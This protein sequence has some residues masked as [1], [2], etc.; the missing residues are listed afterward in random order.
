MG[1]STSFAGPKG[2]GW[3]TAKTS[4]TRLAKGR[5]GYTPRRVVHDAASAITS[6]G[7]A[8]G[9]GGGW[10]GSGASRTA[11]RLGGLLGGAVETGLGDS[12]ERFGI[13]NLHDVP[14]S[15]ALMRLLD[16]VAADAVD[17]NDQAAR[18]AAEDV[19]AQLVH[20]DD[21]DDVF[22]TPLD[23]ERATELFRRFL[24]RYIERAILIALARRLTE[25]ATSDRARDLERQ[26]G[27][28][29]DS[30]VEVTVTPSQLVST[31]WLG[32]EGA[33]L[34]DRLRADALEILSEDD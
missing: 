11:Q 33:A 12:A 23:A 13:A 24:V 15:E 27:R 29:V 22:D 17:L 1:T 14:A 16:W 4:A 3:K 18:K 30:L 5:P 6:G 26:I 31:D 34:V 7:G 8:G 2:P 19:L 32:P 21:L 10:S 28:V 20:E 25:N 9:G